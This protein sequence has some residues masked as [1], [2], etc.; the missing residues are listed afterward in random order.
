MQQFVPDKAPHL[1]LPHQQA[2]E[3]IYGIPEQA[4]KALQFLLD[5][6]HLIR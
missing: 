4:L 3:P 5:L 6:L 2:V 1:L